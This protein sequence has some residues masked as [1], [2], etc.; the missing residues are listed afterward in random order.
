MLIIKECGAGFNNQVVLGELIDVLE[1]LKT[2]HTEVF[3]ARV[4]QPTQLPRGLL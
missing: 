2:K 1:K 4:L 3:R